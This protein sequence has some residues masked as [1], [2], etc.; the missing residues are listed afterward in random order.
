MGISQLWSLNVEEYSY[1]ALSVLAFASRD[2]RV[3][4]GV[5]TAAAAACVFSYSLEGVHGALRIE[6]AAFPLLASGA[7][8]LWL[9]NLR[10]SWKKALFFVSMLAIPI[11]VMV[12]RS[13]HGSVM[14]D[15][16][17]KP[18]MVAIAVNVLDAAPAIVHRLLSMAWLRWFGLCSFSLYLWQGPFEVWVRLGWMNPFIGLAAA[19]ALGAV[20][21]Y[22]FETPM[23]RYIRDEERI[24]SIARAVDRRFRRERLAVS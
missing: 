24:T 21:Y 14:I 3:V 4:A 5:L 17:V 7:L 22:A 11:C 8:N 10:P 2:R 15:L 9:E 20:S 1:I 12:S 19:I 6:C 23:R 18:L 13:V 16:V